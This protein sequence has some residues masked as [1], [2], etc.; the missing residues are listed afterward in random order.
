MSGGP[1][2]FGSFGAGPAASQ[3][4]FCT[5]ASASSPSAPAQPGKPEVFLAQAQ[6]RPGGLDSTAEAGRSSV[7]R[8][9]FFLGFVTE[10]FPFQPF[11]AMRAGGWPRGFSLK[12]RRAGVDSRASREGEL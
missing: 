8:D 7:P 2:S 6:T 9:H 5:V 11:R 3:V 10:E 4:L 1:E 12:L